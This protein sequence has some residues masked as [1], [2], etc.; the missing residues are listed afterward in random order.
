MSIW[1]RTHKKCLER[2]GSFKLS[3]TFKIDQSDLLRMLGTAWGLL[4]VPGAT[5]DTVHN[6][7]VT[8][9]TLQCWTKLLQTSEEQSKTL[10]S[11]R[12][13]KNQSHSSFNVKIASSSA[14]TAGTAASALISVAAGRPAVSSLISSSSVV[15]QQR[16]KGAP[17][18]LEIPPPT[19]NN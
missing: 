10:F 17:T 8:E 15:L 6:P 19:E 2:G 1:A 3:V 11:P 16:L 9:E 4:F 12:K 18:V 7:V 5:F 14:E 13:K